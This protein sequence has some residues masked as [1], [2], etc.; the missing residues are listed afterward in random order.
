[1]ACSAVVGARIGDVAATVVGYPKR[2]AVGLTLLSHGFVL[3]VGSPKRYGAAKGLKIVPPSPGSAGVNEH[4]WVAADQLVPICQIPGHML[5]FGDALPV[6]RVISPPVI[7]GIHIE[8]LPIDI[9]SLLG[10]EFI[11]V[12]G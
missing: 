1:M 5:D 12:I 8:I 7:Q 6:F 9:N 2:D 4:I 3:I 11:N 10:Q